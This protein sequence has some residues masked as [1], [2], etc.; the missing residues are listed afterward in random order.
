MQVLIETQAPYIAVTRIGKPRSKEG[1]AIGLA[2]WRR[3]RSAGV[4]IAVGIKVCSIGIR[5]GTQNF[6]RYDRRRVLPCSNAGHNGSDRRLRKHKPA[7]FIREEEEAMMFSTIVFWQHHWTTKCATKVV[8]AQCQLARV[9]IICKPVGSI[10][11]VIS[12]IFVQSSM[13]FVLSRS[14]HHRDLT[15]RGTSKFWSIS[16]GLNLDLLQVVDR[17]QVCKRSSHI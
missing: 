7:S 16:G 4:S 3:T 13:K 8:V 10:Q 9:Q 11:Y 6:L 1:P 12:K 17:N 2:V 15:T 14:G 5:K